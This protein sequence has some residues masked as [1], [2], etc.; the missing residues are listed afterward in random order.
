MPR[1]FELSQSEHC[2]V[3]RVGLAHHTYSVR[4][5]GQFLHCAVVTSCLAYYAEC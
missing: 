2:G 1:T 3:V 5:T 4:V